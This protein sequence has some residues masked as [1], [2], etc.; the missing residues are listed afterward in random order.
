MK[1]L[2]RRN[3]INTTM[4]GT[5]IAGLSIDTNS[6]PKIPYVDDDLNHLG[7][8]KGYTP[9]IGSLL[10]SLDWVSNTCVTYFPKLSVSDLDYIH[11][12]D[13]NSIGSLLLHI[14]A[15]EVIYQDITFKNL[16]D[17]SKENKEKWGIAMELGE[18]ARNKIKGNP[19]SYYKEAIESVRAITKAEMK[20]RDDTWLISGGTKEWDWNNYCKWFHVVEHYANHRG[21]MAWYVKRIK[22]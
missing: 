10:S 6:R 13:S 8:K 5:T 12:E 15:T 4:L 20:K 11:D 7:P 16:D 1:K 17:F 9:L 3:F 22:Q 19:L 14:A 18:E 21:Q 2:N